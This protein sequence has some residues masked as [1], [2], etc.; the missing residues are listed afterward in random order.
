VSATGAITNVTVDG[1]AVPTAEIRREDRATS[2]THS[3]YTI[4]TAAWRGQSVVVEFT[5]DDPTG[6]IRAWLREFWTTGYPAATLPGSV[7]TATKPRSIGVIDVG[8]TARTLCTIR[9]TAPV[10]G[11]FVYTAPDPN[12]VVRSGSGETV[13]AKFTVASADGD[14]VDVD[15][16]LM[17][18]PQGDHAT[19]VGFTDPQPTELYPDGI[20]PEEGTGY[21]T[22]DA[23][24]RWSYPTDG[25]AAISYFDT[26]GAKALI[27]PRPTL[28][29]GYSGDA[30]V[31]EVHALY[32][33][34]C[35]FAV[36]DVNGDPIAATITYYKRWKHHA[37]E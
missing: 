37:A 36:L 22:A 6:A 23:M 2:A 8:G 15:G 26:T 12:T 1:V 7:E 31:H 16:R 27:S 14:E 29:T 34:R 21:V 4:P 28:P 18:F 25:R 3:I 24:S 9:F 32:P 5:L 10:G 35:G 11:A 33:G 13:F 19:H 17:W 20:W 30:I